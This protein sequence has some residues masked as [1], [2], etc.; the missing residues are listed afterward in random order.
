MMSKV[1][2]LRYKYFSPCKTNCS[3]WKYNV[4][5]WKPTLILRQCPRLN[6]S[7][8]VLFQAIFQNANLTEDGLRCVV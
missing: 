2:L 1:K 8:S 3:Q 4:R 6:D 5:L 7:A